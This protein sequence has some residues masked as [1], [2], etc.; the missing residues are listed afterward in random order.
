MPV[1]EP[2]TF[3]AIP[4]LGKLMA[5]RAN[6][7]R[8]PEAIR[9]LQEQKLRFIVEHAFRHVPFY[10]E[11][12][13]AAGIDPS[14]IRTMKDLALLPMVT[15][16][17]YLDRPLAEVMARGVSPEECLSCSSSGSS[18][19]PLTAYWLP[20][21]R[22]V[23]NL[24]WKR[25]Y[26]ASGMGWR[27]RVAAFSGRQQ[28]GRRGHWHER[29]GFFPR[30]EIS[31]R[32]E[33]PRWVE[34]L[35]AWRPQ[36]ISGSVMTLRLLAEYLRDQQITDVRPRLLFN[37]S[38]LIGESSRRLLA[39]VFACPVID[40]YGSE[41]AGCI[42]WEC[43][44]C[45]GYHLAEDM[46]IVELLKDGRPA[47]PG[48]DGDVVITNLHSRAMPF[49]RY[50]QGDVVKIAHDHPQCGIRFPLISLVEGRN[51][52]FLVLKSGQR[53]PPPP[54]YHCLDPVPGVKRWR[55]LQETAG[56]MRLEL[57]VG[58]DF[59]HEDRLRISRDLRSLT[60]GQMEVQVDLVSEIPVRAGAK[61]RAISSQV[62]KWSV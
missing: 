5:L 18:G 26:L 38:E 1:P 21:D 53:L 44:A 15:R 58:R 48:E 36:V 11:L 8:S 49:I 14:S 55:I 30:R 45:S 2:N 3:H 27:D 41:E 61:F 32:M 20:A 37:S 10:R 12:Y 23:M 19:S 7:R 33:P 50:R 25:A 6:A 39:Q 42:A 43:P 34:I 28:G 40:F 16:K 60:Q 4:R 62:G 29:L 47:R 24:G 13:R 35:R 46:L 31:S 17:D 51:E 56:S 52:D 59:S 57:V 9:R 22:A 54:F